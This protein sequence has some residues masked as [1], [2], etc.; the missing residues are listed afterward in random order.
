[1]RPS[2]KG[3]AA[4]AAILASPVA[5][6]HDLVCEKTVNDM[7]VVHVFTYPTTVTYDW[8][9]TNVL[10]STSIATGITDSMFDVDPPFTVPLPIEDFVTHSEE[11]E[12]PS[13][14]RC[15]ELAE[16]EPNGDITLENVLTVVF[17]GSNSPQEC[18]AKVICHPPE[19]N[20]EEGCFTRTPGYWATHPEI[21]DLFLPLESCGEELGTTEVPPGEGLLSITEDLCSVGKD[22]EV[23]GSPQEAQLVRQCAAAALN[24]AASVELGAS[25]TE[26]VEVFE[27]CCLSCG[28]VEAG[29][30]DDLDEFNNSADTL[31]DDGEEINLCHEFEVPCAADPDLCQDAKNNGVVNDRVVVA[32]QETISAAGAGGPTTGG[33]SGGPGGLVAL[34]GAL[35]ALALR[36]RG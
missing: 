33:C 9:I 20:G 8:T 16:V 21:T 30:I 32:S 15:A 17:D 29:C 35:G 25:C 6:A 13:Y 27:D 3:V 19:Q 18:K 28:T 2:W 11:L 26:G 36:R 24:I 14:E 22:H 5:S 4:A 1:M 12:I 31:L 7:D 34:L 10:S 23:Y